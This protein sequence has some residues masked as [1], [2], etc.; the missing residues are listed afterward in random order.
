MKYTVIVPVYN[1]EDTIEQCLRS[2]I[3]QKNAVYNSDYTILVVDDGSTDRT[4]QIAAG[5]PVEIIRLPKNEGRIIARLT[6]ARKAETGRVLFVDSRVTVPGDTIAKLDDFNEYPAVIGE[7][8]SE[9]M[10]YESAFHTILYLIRRRYYGKEY[11]PMRGSELHITK[12]NFKRAPKGTAVL[13]IDRDLFISLTP[14]RTGKNVND[15]TLLFQSLVFNHKLGLLRSKR[16]FF[17]YSQRTNP[18]QFAAWLF[19]RGVRFADFYLRPGG[20]FFIP[21]LLILVLIAVAGVVS[22][23][24]NPGA[25]YPIFWTACALNGVIAFYLAENQ[26]DF[27]I[28]FIAL[29]PI[30]MIFGAGVGRFWVGILKT[31]LAKHPKRGIESR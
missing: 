7:L 6:G 15:D 20:Y 9:E 29:P 5:F 2:L 21:F 18:R 14:E 16:L 10:K 30:L 8:N 23:L 12:D 17:K 4:A 26:K 27:L 1:G 28:A 31:S 24:R 11:F 3:D 13:L 22:P 19:H 25:F